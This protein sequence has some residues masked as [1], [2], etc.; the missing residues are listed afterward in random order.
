MVV[1]RF[2]R[3]KFV[4]VLVKHLALVH[5]SQEDGLCVPGCTIYCTLPGGMLFLYFNIGVLVDSFC[6]VFKLWAASAHV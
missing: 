6:T 5:L 4:E 3:L 2:V 1:R